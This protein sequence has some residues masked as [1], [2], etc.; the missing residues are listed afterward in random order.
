VR[1]VDRL[2]AAYYA[3]KYRQFATFGSRVRVLGRLTLQG[4]GRITID[5][6]VI[7]GSGG[8]NRICAAEGGSVTIGARSFLNGIEIFANDTVE[9]GREC[10]IGDCWISTSDFHAVGRNRANPSAMVR[11]GPVCIGQNVWLAA[12]TAVLRG[13]SIGDDSVVA[14]GTVVAEDVPPGVVVAGQKLRVVRELEPSPQT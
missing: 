6:M 5:D 4:P 14:F 9:I 8:R 7:F 10:I 2:R 13:V 12:R 11:T 3:T 1:G